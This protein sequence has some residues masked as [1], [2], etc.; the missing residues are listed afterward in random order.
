MEGRWS[1][2]N[3][4]QQLG[5]CGTHLQSQRSEGRG[6]RISE[7]KANLVYRAI[8]STAQAKQ[9]NPPAS[10]NSQKSER[11]GL[12]KREEE[13]NRKGEKTWVESLS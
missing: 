3:K 8:S 4:R 11:E 9:R 13:E 6:R 1:V 5:G 12:E 7:F 2:E 10:S